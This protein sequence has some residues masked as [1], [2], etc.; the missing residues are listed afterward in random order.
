MENKSEHTSDPPGSLQQPGSVI[1]TVAEIR[2]LANFAGLNVAPPDGKW[3]GDESEQ[4]ITVAPCPKGGVFDEDSNKW[5]H[6]KRIAYFTEYPEEGVYPLGDE[7]SP[8]EKLRHG[9]KETHE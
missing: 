9:E 1:L 8:N 3:D 5:H 2:Q 4:E 6:F 7:I